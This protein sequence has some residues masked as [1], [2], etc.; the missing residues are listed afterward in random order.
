M[1]KEEI[2][3]QMICNMRTM[4]R[5]E[6]LEHLDQIE[7]NINFCSF[8]TPEQHLRLEVVSELRKKI[9]EDGDI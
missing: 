5:S 2:R 6:M 3:I 7:T 8:I 1:T 4:S 9:I